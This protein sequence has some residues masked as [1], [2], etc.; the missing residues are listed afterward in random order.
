MTGDEME[1]IIQSILGN[2]VAA[3][4]RQKRTPEQADKLL[5]RSAARLAR[6]DELLKVNRRN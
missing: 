3:G 2:R 6:T 5:K 1:R 4:K